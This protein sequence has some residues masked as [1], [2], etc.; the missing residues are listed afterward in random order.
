M[1]GLKRWRRGPIARICVAYEAAATPSGWPA[2]CGRAASRHPPDE[3]LGVAREHRRAKTDRLDLGLLERSFLGRL[4]GEKKHCS[5]MA[6]P[7]R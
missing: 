6:V 2:G 4:R 3:R 1:E 7:T 5:M